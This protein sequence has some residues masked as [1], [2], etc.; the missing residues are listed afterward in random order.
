MQFNVAQLL[1]QTTGATRHYE[2]DEPAGIS[3]PALDL[4]GN[5]HGNA[6]LLRTQRGVLVTADLHQIVRLQCVRCL[7]D[8]EATLDIVLEEEF[9]PSIDLKTGLLIQWD[10]EGEEFEDAVMIDGN[11]ILDLREVTRQWLLVNLPAQPLCRPDCAG[12]CPVCGADRNVEPCKCEAQEGDAR[13][14]A[15]AD[16]ARVI[17]SED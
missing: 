15:L 5:I 7:A 10:A 17:Q 12:I 2:I 3:D 4:V 14:A 6:T 8:V 11:H 13:W 9:Y 16:L 1:R